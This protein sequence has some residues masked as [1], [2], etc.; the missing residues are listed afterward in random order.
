MSTS[1]GMP[2]R[3]QQIGQYWHVV[4]AGPLEQQGWTACPQVV[5]AHRAQ[6]L[7]KSDWLGDAGKVTIPLQNL[8]KCAQA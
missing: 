5:D 2:P 4:V 6:L 8:E 1:D 7:I 3:G